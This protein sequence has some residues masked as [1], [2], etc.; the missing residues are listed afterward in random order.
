VRAG[1]PFLDSGKTGRLHAG[2]RDGGLLLS[3]GEEAREKE[4]VDTLSG[5]EKGRFKAGKGKRRIK[6][7][8]N[9][10]KKRICV[11]T[12]KGERRRE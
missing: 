11:F 8:C 6:A 4:K 7:T 1:R 10:E 9:L 12:R 2:S 5:R 3:P